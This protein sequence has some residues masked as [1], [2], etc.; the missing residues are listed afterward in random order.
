M[1]PFFLLLMI[2][3]LTISCE[4]E[5][6]YH[7]GHYEGGISFIDITWEINGGEILINNS[8][9]GTSK[10]RCEQ[11]S[12]RIEYLEKD[13]TTKILY[14]QGNGDLKMSDLIILHKIK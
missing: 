6:H 1:K 7:D 11:F 12:D 8:I 13:G 3:I 10:L 2:L 4:S 14:A 5:N 9:T